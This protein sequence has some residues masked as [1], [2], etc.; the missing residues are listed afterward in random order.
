MREMR[1]IVLKSWNLA[2][3]YIFEAIPHQCP[4]WQR[5]SRPR[6]WLFVG[7]ERLGRLG[8]P[9]AMPSIHKATRLHK[10]NRLKS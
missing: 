7:S 3:I 5:A 1:E 4:T 6:A 2:A 9:S 10:A 8:R